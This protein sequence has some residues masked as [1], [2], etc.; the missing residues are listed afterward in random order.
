[1]TTSW[2]RCP[3]HNVLFLYPSEALPGDDVQRAARWSELM[4]RILAHRL[5]HLCLH[6]FLEESYADG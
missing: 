6:R 3:R 4:H 1:M 2:L 5:S